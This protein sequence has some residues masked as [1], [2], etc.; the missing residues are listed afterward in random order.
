MEQLTDYLNVEKSN[1]LEILF[2]KNLPAGRQTREWFDAARNTIQAAVEPTLL[3]HLDSLQLQKLAASKTSI[4]ELE[5]TDTNI[6]LFPDSFN[7]TLADS[8]DK[9]DGFTMPQ[10]FWL[11]SVLLDMFEN[12]AAERVRTI[13]HKR[14]Q[15]IAR[16]RQRI[17][18]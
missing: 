4:E 3:A 14:A 6:R 18:S 5:A 1:I 17:L 13:F 15:E 11:F 16:F 7:K 10:K 2:S 8:I 12:A 9:L